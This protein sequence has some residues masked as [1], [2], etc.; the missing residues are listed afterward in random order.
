MSRASNTISLQEF[1]RLTGRYRRPPGVAVAHGAGDTTSFRVLGIDTA[2]RRTG[3]GVVEFNSGRPRAI[4]YGAIASPASA[5][6]TACL[7]L[8]G[9]SVSDL[10]A[11]AKPDAVAIEGVFFSRNVRTTLALG[12][13]R[14]VVIYTCAMA[15]VPVCEYPPR[16]VKQ[17]VVGFGG[18]EKQQVARMVASML[19]LPR[20]PQTD[21]AD[22]L[23]IAI[24]HLHNRSQHAMLAA[25]S[26]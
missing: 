11:R 5:P 3:Y 24:C 1:A 7:K 17:A 20:P 4:E 19:G 21:A 18:A 16:R 23:A 13:A 9:K 22:A 15:G 6:T 10:L 8:L 26:L 2:L 25:D 14:G 12:E